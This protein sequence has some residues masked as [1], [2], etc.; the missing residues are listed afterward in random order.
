MPLDNVTPFVLI[1]ET[2]ATDPLIRM[3]I[4]PIAKEVV[5]AYK[6]TY[7][8]TWLIANPNYRRLSEYCHWKSITFNPKNR[9]LRQFLDSPIRTRSYATDYSP[10][11]A[12]LIALALRVQTEMPNAEFV[13]D[14]FDTDPVLHVTYMFEGEKKKACLGIWD[15]GV[16][17]ALATIR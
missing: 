1:D 2:T 10:A 14:Y 8:K 11:P 5:L 4:V 17:Q 7:R 9:T 3:G 15:C 16:I 13:V 6:K 12:D